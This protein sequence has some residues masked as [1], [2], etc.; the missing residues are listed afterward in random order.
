M[1]PLSC[2][3]DSIDFWRNEMPERAEVSCLMPNGILILTVVPINCTIREI[4]TVS[5]N[6]NNKNTFLIL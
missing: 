1:A 6:E 4:K 5:F 3:T 2:P